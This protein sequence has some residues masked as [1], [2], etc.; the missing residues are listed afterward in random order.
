MISTQNEVGGGYIKSTV[1]L[2]MLVRDVMT[3]EVIAI[4][5]YESIMQVANI[6]SENNISGIPVVDKDNKVV[7][8]ITQADILSLLGVRREHTFK[9][10]LKHML[11][12]PL[13]E[14]R[15]G[16]HVGD[17][18]TSPAITIKPDAN[19]AEAVRILDERKI[20]RLTV[21]DEK[22]ILLGIITRADILKAVIRKLK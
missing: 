14:R 11:G 3:K 6:L 18:M 10:L 17:I 5:K 9:D 1:G 12:E 7:G 4:T 16:D 13:P 21:V 22:N 15:M 2:D 19:I 20:R 8:I